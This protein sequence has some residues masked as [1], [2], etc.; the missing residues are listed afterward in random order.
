MMGKGGVCKLIDLGMSS[1]LSADGTGPPA[2][3]RYLTAYGKPSYMSPEAAFQEPVDPFA[4]DVWSLGILLYMLLTGS[5]LYGTRSDDAF[6]LLRLGRL[7]EVLASYKSF[8]V[9]SLS[10]QARDLIGAMLNP[11]PRLRLTLAQVRDHPWMGVGA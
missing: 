6:V 4:A 8:G 5:P 1:R 11:D 10:P 9:T 7:D 3:L 2:F